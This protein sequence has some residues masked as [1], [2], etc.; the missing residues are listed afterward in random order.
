MLSESWKLDRSQKPYLLQEHSQRGADIVAPLQKRIAAKIRFA[1]EEI[2][3]AVST[4][5][6]I[7]HP[8]WILKPCF[9]R[10]LCGGKIRLRSPRIPL[11]CGSQVVAALKHHSLV[12]DFPRKQHVGDPR[13]LHIL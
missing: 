13:F 10:S 11:A 2:W 1:E 3:R 4:R 12:A 5:Q 9:N 7:D 6:S 8:Y